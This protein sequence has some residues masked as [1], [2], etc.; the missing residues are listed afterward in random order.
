MGSATESGFIIMSENSIPPLDLMHPQQRAWLEGIYTRYQQLAPKPTNA[1]SSSLEKELEHFN[2]LWESL[3]SA[4]SLPNVSEFEQQR[5]ARTVQRTQQ[6][7][8]RMQQLRQTRTARIKL[9]IEQRRNESL[10]QLRRKKSDLSASNQQLEESSKILA[11][12][13]HEYD[14]CLQQKH[15]TFH[16]AVEQRVQKLGVELTQLADSLKMLWEKNESE[17]VRLAE[18]EQSWSSDEKH[19]IESE[20]LTIDWQ[21]RSRLLDLKKNRLQ[22]WS[23]SLQQKKSALHSRKLQANSTKPSRSS[24]FSN[25]NPAS[26]EQRRYWLNKSRPLR[27]LLRTYV[28]LTVHCQN[29]K[30]ELSRGG[31]LN[32]DPAPD[33]P[34]KFIDLPPGW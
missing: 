20:Q 25:W 4:T 26:N 18:D 11:Q 29:L 16:Q 1:S 33:I 13:Q 23:S 24:M 22:N 21:S 19:F 7:T 2:D 14:V 27:E 30:A 17:A 8:E 28:Q 34:N 10:D 12:L 31:F 32:T 15:M 3:V 5:N 6:R 9:N